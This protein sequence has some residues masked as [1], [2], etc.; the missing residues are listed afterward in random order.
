MVLCPV[1]DPG[2]GPP[3]RRQRGARRLLSRPLVCARGATRTIRPATK[4]RCAPATNCSRADARSRWLARSRPDGEQGRRSS[5][6]ATVAPRSNAS[7][8][9]AERFA[10]AQSRSNAGRRDL[11]RTSGASRGRDAAAGVR[12]RPAPQDRLAVNHRAKSMPLPISSTG[13]QKA[14]LLGLVPRPRRHC[15][16]AARAAD[17]ACS[18]KSPPISTP[19]AAPLCSPGSKL[20]P[21]VDDGP[22]KPSF[23]SIGK[24]R[25][26]ISKAGAVPL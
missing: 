16:S 6:V 12:A 2:D 9:A 14:L 7:N 22:P 21:G 26:F 15:P 18:P 13:E 19:A 10:S 5:E 4:R 1:A 20:R 8:H 25:A 24:P 23:D 11:G 17:P 3:V